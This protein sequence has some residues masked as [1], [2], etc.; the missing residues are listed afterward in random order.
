MRR[1]YQAMDFVSADPSIVRSIR[2]RAMLNAWLRLYAQLQRPPEFEDFKLSRL[3]DELDEIVFYL[4]ESRSDATNFKIESDGRRTYQAYGRTGKG[5]YLDEYIPPKVRDLVVPVYK[6]CVRRRLPVFTVAKVKDINGIEVEF[7][8]LLLP[9]SGASG[10]ERLIASLNAISIDGKFEIK[11]L[12][13]GV[14]DLPTYDILS[15]IDQKL[16]HHQPGKM[17]IADVH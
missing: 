5:R 4:V 2:Q 12:M 10:I 14:T 13:M 6:E 3:S 8:R 16:F 15:V 9:F 1:G 17:A 11:N 7:E